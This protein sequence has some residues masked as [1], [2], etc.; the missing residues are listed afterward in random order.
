MVG[1]KSKK[2]KDFYVFKEILLLDVGFDI[3]HY[4]LFRI[5]RNYLKQNVFLLNVEMVSL[6]LSEKNICMLCTFSNTINDILILY[7]K[8]H[9]EIE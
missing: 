1:N 6:N 4:V 5:V 9:L 8:F 3:N 2:I 7:T